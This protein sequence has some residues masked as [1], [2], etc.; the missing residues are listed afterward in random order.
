M[1]KIVLV[2]G[3]WLTA[4][5]WKNVA[6]RFEAAGHEVLTP[7]WPGYGEV[8]EMR[9]H[10][11]VANGLGV[12]EITDHVEKFIRDHNAE[13]AIIMGHSF[14][15]LITQKLLDRGLGKAGVA[16]HSAPAKGT[17]GLPFSSLKAAFPVLKNPANAKRNVALTAEEWHFAFTN[18]LPEAEAEALREKWAITAPG[19]P[20]WQ[21]ATANFTTHNATKVDYKNPNRAPLLF[22]ASES[23]NVVPASMNRENARRYRTASVTEIKEFP[24]R[25]HF[26]MGTEGWEEVAD[27]ALTWADKF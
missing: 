26:V 24:G 19:R 27:Y 7:T 6:E 15:G 3:L 23:D 10:P 21:A 13:D 1:S 25:P 4:G 8:A 20:L 16:I 11:E 22:I 9:A 12:V 18:T 5:S 2:H 17:L 14:G